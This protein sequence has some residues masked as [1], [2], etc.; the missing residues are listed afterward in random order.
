MRGC[1]RSERRA[2]PRD[3]GK[4][5]SR[6]FF[7]FLVPE[8]AVVVAK[9][10]RGGFEEVSR[11]FRRGFEEVSKRFRGGFEEV[12]RRFERVWSRSVHRMK[13]THSLR[14]RG[15]F[16]PSR[17]RRATGIQTNPSA[18]KNY[19]PSPFPLIT[20]RDARTIHSN[21]HRVHA[22]CCL[23]LLCHSLMCTRAGSPALVAPGT[24]PKYSFPE[25][26]SPK[27][28]RSRVKLRRQGRHRARH[29]SDASFVRHSGAVEHREHVQA[30]S[31]SVI[32]G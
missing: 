32:L 23:S 13:T 8:R 2:A 7:F 6:L 9:R 16:P 28:K 17:N 11:T 20:A 10:F 27:T 30:A 29:S 21:A 4:K 26:F 25:L 3:P 15:L 19:F 12:S 24:P 1:A 5:I 18:I 22:V 31:V 14:A